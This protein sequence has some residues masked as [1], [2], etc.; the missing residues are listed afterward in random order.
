VTVNARTPRAMPAAAP[1]PRPFDAE[2][3][4]EWAWIQPR[5]MTRQWELHAGRD[6]VAVLTARGFLRQRVTARFESAAW[7]IRHHF[8]GGVTVHAPGAAEPAMR[9]RPGWFW[10]GRIERTGG[11]ALQWRRDSFWPRRWAIRT[12]EQLPLVRL[13]ARSGFLRAAAGVELEDAARRLPDLG[14]LLALAWVLVLSSRRSHAS[15]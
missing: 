2:F 6:V 13:T 11:P 4:G 15:E 1:D 14:P 3:R 9:F 8:P 7:E 5:R 10:G 12:A